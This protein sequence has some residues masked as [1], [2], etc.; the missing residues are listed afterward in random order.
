LNVDLAIRRAERNDADAL[1]TLMGELGYATR[2]AEM[3][4][5]LDLILN[6][7][8]YATFV[9]VSSGR[10]CGMIGTFCHHSYEHNGPSG[11]ILALVVSKDRRRSGV[12]RALIGAAENDFVQRNIRRVGLNTRFERE[13]A[14]AF[15]ESAGYVRTG[16]RFV[17]E[18]PAA[19][20]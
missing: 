4:M 3:E 11:R 18:L 7:A 5:R 17:K 8:R 10:V 14:H 16:F 12:A 2:A 20:D 13:D 19:A 15:Y 9:A 6:D 1:A